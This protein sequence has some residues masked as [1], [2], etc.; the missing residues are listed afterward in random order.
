MAARGGTRAGPR[1]DFPDPGGGKA[2]PY[3][4]Y[5]LAATTGR[6]RRHRPRHLP[7]R[8]GIGPPL[9]GRHRQRPLPARGAAAGHLRRRRLQRLP[10]PGRGRRNWPRS[11][12]DRAGDHRL[13]LPARHVEVEQDRAPAVLPDH[14]HLAGP[15]ADQL[16]GHREHHRRDDHH[17]RADRH[18][19]PGRRPLPDRHRSHRRADEDLEDRVIARHGF[20]GDWNYT[21]LPAPRPAP[22][23]GPAPAPPAPVRPA[24][25]GH[26]GPARAH[27]AAARRRRRPGRR[28]GPSR[29]PPTAQP[30]CTPAAAAAPASAPTPPATTPGTR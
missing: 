20:H 18:R 4:V 28:P 3:G 14:P 22:D 21:I 24:P 12:A 16:R 19:R 2:I 8:R 9:V 6:Q 26:L 5:D 30:G 29:T 1:H 7:V 23:P 10:A 11:R 15:P 13:P 25:P 17:H 27:R